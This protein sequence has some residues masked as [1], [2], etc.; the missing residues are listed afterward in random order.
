M[1]LSFKH[2]KRGVA[3][4]RGDVNAN[5]RLYPTG[6]REGHERGTPCDGESRFDGSQVGLARQL[7]DDAHTA[8]EMGHEQCG[9]FRMVAGDEGCDSRPGI[10]LPVVVTDVSS[11]TSVAA[12]S[13]PHTR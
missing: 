13:G 9:E 11:E 2:L 1:T 5:G 3:G 4:R 10:G 6:R 12:P 8:R 7:E